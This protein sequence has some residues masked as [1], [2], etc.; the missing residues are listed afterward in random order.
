[1]F[2]KTRRTSAFTLIELLVVIAIIAILAAILFPVFAQARDK[3]RQ[4]ACL[5]NEKQMGTATMMYAQDYDECFP[6]A[7]RDYTPAYFTWDTAISTYIK[8]GVVGGGGNTGKGGEVFRCPNDN[9]KHYT[10]STVGPDASRD[11]AR[12]YSMA[13]GQNGVG[14]SQNSPT[15]PVPAV[16]KT[17]A[18]VP[19]A[20][21]TILFAECPLPGTPPPDNGIGNITG[22]SSFATA[23]CPENQRIGAIPYQSSR[24]IPQ[25]RQPWHAGGWNYTFCDGHSKWFRPEKTIG[26]PGVTV[27]LSNG[28]QCNGKDGSSGSASDRPCGMWTLDDND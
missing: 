4:T 2:S 5:S 18:D 12:S 17:L 16:P 27:T 15:A 7:N 23:D 14:V 10:Y 22:Y 28:N 9:D 24:G 3:A 13:R 19:A 11:G 8:M 6:M 1:M 26:K 25:N 21:D 20:A